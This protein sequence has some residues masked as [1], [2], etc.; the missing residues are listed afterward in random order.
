MT[1]LRT[2]LGIVCDLMSRIEGNQPYVVPEDYREL[3]ALLKR[4]PGARPVNCPTD[5]YIARK[6][7][8]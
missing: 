2:A 8:N 4:S 1:Q 6:T 3:A 7:T 5:D